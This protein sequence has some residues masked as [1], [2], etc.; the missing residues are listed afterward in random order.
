MNQ[1]SVKYRTIY[2]DSKIQVR[3]RYPED[4]VVCKDGLEELLDLMVERI[5]DLQRRL[6]YIEHVEICEQPLAHIKKISMGAYEMESW[7]EHDKLDPDD[8]VSDG[9]VKS[10]GSDKL[11]VDER[12]DK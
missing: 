4:K 12:K 11:K 10:N 6:N 3:K 9:E 2:E 8:R 7:R 5:N 1:F